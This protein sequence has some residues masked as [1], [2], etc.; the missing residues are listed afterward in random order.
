MPKPTLT[1]GQI[2][3]VAIGLLDEE[4]LDGLNMRALGKRLDSAPTAVYWHVKDKDNLIRL[5]SDKVWNEIALPDDDGGD[6]RTAAEQLASGL[7]A[8][9]LRHPWITQALSG[10]LLYGPGKSRFDDCTLGVYERAGF[11][12]AQADQAAATVFVFVLGSAM[13]DAANV[14]LTRRLDRKGGDAQQ[15]LQ[16]A[17]RRATDIGAQFPRLRAR[18]ET[19]GTGTGYNDAP[20]HTFEFGLKAIL[21][22]LQA[23]L[24]AEEALRTAARNAQAALDEQQ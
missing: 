21:D 3:D 17:I 16:E 7:R 23:R 14:S 8:M 22:G 13:G 9:V 24:K 19:D 12:E 4:G 18:L 6:W 2:V 20:D 15:Q 11:S 1:A 5:A 10:Y